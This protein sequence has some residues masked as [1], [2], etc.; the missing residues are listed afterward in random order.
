IYF[1][2]VLDSNFILQFKVNGFNYNSSLYLMLLGY[3]FFLLRGDLLSSFSF[4]V[5]ALV[6]FILI[7]FIMKLSR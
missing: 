3:I 2:S 4:L 5:S 7:K 1:I 6:A